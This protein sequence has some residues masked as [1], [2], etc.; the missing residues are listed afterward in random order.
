MKYPDINYF[1]SFICLLIKLKIP[2][3]YITLTYN[4]AKL[5]ESS[6]IRQIGEKP[7]DMQCFLF[8]TSYCSYFIVNCISAI[9]HVNTNSSNKYVKKS[10]MI[11][12]SVLVSF[13]DES[14]FLQEC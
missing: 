7:D 5:K 8:P 10:R 14:D 4:I 12:V 1:C 2:R 3:E 6:G 13:V 9:A 11:N